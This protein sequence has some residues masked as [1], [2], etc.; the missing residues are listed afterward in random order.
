M[1]DSTPTPPSDR[2]VVLLDPAVVRLCETFVA[3]VPER[4]GLAVF[5]ASEVLAGLQDERTQWFKSGW[6]IIDEHIDEHIGE[7]CDHQRLLLPDDPARAAT[8]CA[9]YHPGCT[10]DE[11][12]NAVATATDDLAKRRSVDL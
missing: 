3:N 4:T 8:L 1:A 2:R 9:T 7:R 10:H 11:W 12:I 6:P 5:L